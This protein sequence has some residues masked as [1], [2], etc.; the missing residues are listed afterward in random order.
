MQTKLLVW[1]TLIILLVITASAW[2]AAQV[3]ALHHPVPLASSS[4]LLP[5]VAHLIPAPLR[6]GSRAR[7]PLWPVLCRHRSLACGQPWYHHQRLPCSV[8]LIIQQIQQLI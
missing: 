1:Q 7:R 4:P 5:I 6:A 2:L 3:W 8:P